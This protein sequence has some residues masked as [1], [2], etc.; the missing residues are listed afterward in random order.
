VRAT[1]IGLT[2]LR[3][4]N[5][6]GRLPGTWTSNGRYACGLHREDFSIATPSLPWRPGYLYDAPV[7]QRTQLGR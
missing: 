3:T 6:H 7:H 1:N 5:G 2:A 4:N